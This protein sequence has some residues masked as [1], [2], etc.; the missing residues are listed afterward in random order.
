M[1]QQLTWLRAS[2]PAFER[3]DFLYEERMNKFRKTDLGKFFADALLHVGRR[4]AGKDEFSILETMAAVHRAFG[5][6]GVRSTPFFVPFHWHSTALTILINRFHNAVRKLFLEE[7]M[8]ILSAFE[9][10]CNAV[11]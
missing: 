8:K 6:I 2:L 1:E 5:S 3:W 10:E 9:P 11:S 7:S 4:D